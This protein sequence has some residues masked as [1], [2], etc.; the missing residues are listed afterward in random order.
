MTLACR[1]RL[2]ALPRAARQGGMVDPHGERELDQMVHD[3]LTELSQK[4]D[5]DALGREEPA[6]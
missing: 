6:P 1:G 4:G 3:A 2:L 5:D